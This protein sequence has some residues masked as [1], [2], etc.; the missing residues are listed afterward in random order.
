M[1][2]PSTSKLAGQLFVVQLEP[3]VTRESRPHPQPVFGV[4]RLRKTNIWRE[5]SVV[6]PPPIGE[7]L[8]DLVNG[9]WANC[10]RL[11]AHTKTPQLT[12]LEYTTVCY[13][14]NH[15]E[16]HAGS[17][18]QNLGSSLLTVATPLRL[19]REFSSSWLSPILPRRSALLLPNGAGTL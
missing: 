11:G 1:K 10:S 19:V 17:T 18:Q 8:P 14:V 2:L 7:G 16:S 4:G 6:L 3:N 15:D 13:F 12:K 5:T 9:L